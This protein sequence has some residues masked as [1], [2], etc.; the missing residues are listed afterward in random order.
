[1]VSENALLSNKDTYVPNTVSGRTID[2]S[3]ILKPNNIIHTV[4][5]SMVL[6]V[7]NHNKNISK[8]KRPQVRFESVGCVLR[9]Y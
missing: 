4:I 2:N 9:I 8:M 6:V 3:R 7:D 5:R 1:M